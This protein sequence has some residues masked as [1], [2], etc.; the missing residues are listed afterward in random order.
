MGVLQK[1][2]PGVGLVMFQH[3]S[4]G[5]FGDVS[6]LV[7]VGLVMFQYFS[8]VGLVMFQYW[9]GVGLVMFQHWSGVGLVM[10]QY[11]SGGWFGDVSILV[12]GLVW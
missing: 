11:W 2:N 5:W 4:G 7:R 12:R 3:W 10:F 8:G 6:I 1:K 9:S